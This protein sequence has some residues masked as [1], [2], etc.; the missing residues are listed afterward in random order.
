MGVILS[1]LPKEIVLPAGVGNILNFSNATGSSALYN[2]AQGNY[3][4][5]LQVYN[6]KVAITQQ[7]LVSLNELYAYYKPYEAM[8]AANNWNPVI[9]FVLWVEGYGDGG[10]GSTRANTYKKWIGGTQMRRLTQACERLTADNWNYIYNDGIETGESNYRSCQYDIVRQW[11]S[12]LNS[13]AEELDRAYNNA[14]AEEN[15]AKTAV[16]NAKAELDRAVALEQQ[17]S[18]QRIK[19]NMTDPAFIAAQAKAAQNKRLTY[20][21][22]G[23]LALGIAVAGGALIFKK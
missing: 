11:L 5:K 23:V 22:A 14:K 4:S 6:Q 19:E 7:K 18:D 8:V 12:S 2:Q 9:R 10:Y 15:T 13:K 1:M 21:V 16:D 3:N 20:V 17:A